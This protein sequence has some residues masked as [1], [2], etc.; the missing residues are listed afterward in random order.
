MGDI[1]KGAH[2]NSLYYLWNFSVNLEY[3]NLFKKTP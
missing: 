3:K 2:E 1:G